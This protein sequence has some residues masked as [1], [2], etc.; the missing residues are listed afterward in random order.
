MKWLR[1]LL[2]VGL[3]LAAGQSMA[4][5][6]SQVRDWVNNL[7]SQK[8]YGRGYVFEGAQKAADFV[9]SEFERMGV[10]QVYQQSFTSPVNQFPGAMSL[11]IDGQ[12]LRP[13]LDFLPDG[14]SSTLKGTFDAYK[15]NPEQLKDQAAFPDIIRAARNKFLIVDVSSEAQ[16]PVE[17]Q[18][19]MQSLLAYLQNENN[20][21]IAGAMVITDKKLTHSVGNELC[22]LPVIIVDKQ[23]VGSTISKVKINLKAKLESDYEHRNVVA[24][25]KGT[26]TPE[27]TVVFTAH[28]DHLGGFGEGTYFPGAND[29]AS[30]TA[31]ILA[32]ADYYTQNPPEYSVVLIAFGA[33][34]LGLLGSRYYIENPLFP[35]NSIKWLINMDMLGTGEEGIKVVNGTFHKEEFARLQS[36]NEDGGYLPK[37]SPRGEACNS[38]HCFFHQQ[39]VPCF[40]IYTLGGIQAYHDP[41]DKAETLPLTGFAGVFQLITDFVATL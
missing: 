8:M 36:I 34:E 10:S 7:A 30:G 41:L 4:Q 37:V 23:A 18:S 22:W 6:M 32:L 1:N 40:F 15:V 21:G 9:A 19:L 24:L 13:G 16:V 31:M 33:E 11:S 27:E 29:N 28:Y 26:K 25:I 14:C 2:F 38:D 20:Q 17:V 5:D 39:E 12:A 3:G 35:I